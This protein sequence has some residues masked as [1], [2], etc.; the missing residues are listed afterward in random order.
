MYVIGD[1]AM[2]VDDSCSTGSQN[3]PSFDSSTTTFDV[4]QMV[5]SSF[6]ACIV[7]VSHMK[8]ADRAASI[9]TS[10]LNA[11]GGDNSC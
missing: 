1:S 11:I 5:Y 8:M 10:P 2:I 6:G 4:T 3:V 9:K 7:T